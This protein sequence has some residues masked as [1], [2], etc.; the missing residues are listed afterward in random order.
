MANT[1]DASLLVGYSAT[2]PLLQVSKLVGYSATLPELQVAKLVGYSATLPELQ[3]SKLVGYVALVHPTDLEVSKLVSYA[4]LLPMSS[5]GDIEVSKLVGYAALFPAVIPPPPFLPA[6]DL[7]VSISPTS[8]AYVTSITNRSFN[9]SNAP[10]PT[11]AD[12]FNEG[13][14]LVFLAAVD[15]ANAPDPTAT[16]TFTPPV[17]PPFTATV[18]RVYVGKRWLRTYLGRLQPSTY[19]VYVFAPN[20][21]IPGLW[22]LRLQFTPYPGAQVL[23]DAGT[24]QIPPPIPQVF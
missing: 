6:R 17:G 11:A 18:P 20:V 16:I 15:V 1:I 14:I 5:S 9:V 4:V 3:V 7:I 21:L 22:R 10:R 23:N 19:L 13:A 8:G 24:F 2:F 12:L